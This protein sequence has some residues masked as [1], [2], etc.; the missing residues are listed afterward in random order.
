VS[1]N[2]LS[3]SLDERFGDFLDGLLVLKMRNNELEGSLP[4]SLGGYGTISQFGSVAESV[5]RAHSSQ[6]R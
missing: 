4:E 6:C 2:G 5:F 1:H 3:G